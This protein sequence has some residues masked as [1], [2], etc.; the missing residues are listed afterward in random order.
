MNEK[1]IRSKLP[2]ATDKRVK[3]IARLLAVTPYP[4]G[5]TLT[6]AMRLGIA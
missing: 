6:E 1:Q 2:D 3:E 5:L 4:K